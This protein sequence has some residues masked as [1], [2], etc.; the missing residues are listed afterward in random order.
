VLLKG[1]ILCAA[2]A[3]AALVGCSTKGEQVATLEETPS[4]DWSEQRA[5]AEAMADCL[6]GEGVPARLDLW[7]DGQ[8]GVAF[9]PP[10]D[11]WVMCRQDTGMCNG[12]GAEELS[13]A[14]QATK[15]EETDKIAEAYQVSPGDLPAGQFPPGYLIVGV[16]DYT[17]QYRTCLA[18][19]GY[20]FPEAQSDPNDELRQKQEKAE[21]ANAWAACA[22]ANGL[23]DV[24]DADPPRADNWHSHPLA[25]LPVTVSEDLL[26]EVVAKCPPFDLDARERGENPIEPDIGFNVRGWDG[27]TLPISGEVDPATQER[28]NSLFHIIN[29]PLTKWNEQHYGK[30]E[31]N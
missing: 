5:G 12:G 25:V 27:K 4:T 31:L 10:D 7:T 18:Q 30:T 3:V 17:D 2:C 8:A 11:V 20:V 6:V 19:T 13:Q 23:S 9:D 16:T 14:V 29:E 15:W 26:R 28:M 21:A 22:R 1:L 24:K